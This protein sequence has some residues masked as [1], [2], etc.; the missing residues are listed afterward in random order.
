M[1]ISARLLHFLVLCRLH[2]RMMLSSDNEKSARQHKNLVILK[3]NIRRPPWRFEYLFS[4]PTMTCSALS[5]LK[6]S[7]GFKTFWAR[8]D[9]DQ[10]CRT[11]WTKENP[12]DIRVAIRRV[13]FHLDNEISLS[14]QASVCGTRH[15]RCRSP[16][17]Q[18][19]PRST[20]A[21]W[22]PIGEGKASV[23]PA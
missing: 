19:C 3:A 8:R 2:P 18:I 14:E 15:T 21:T 10:S 23:S 6:T 22:V 7:L 5:S 16:M 11:T 13:P 12:P 4:L 17:T 20:L 9:L 1:G